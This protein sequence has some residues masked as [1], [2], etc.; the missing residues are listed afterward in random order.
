MS[1]SLHDAEIIAYS[2]DLETKEIRL[3]VDYLER[4]KVGDEWRVKCEMQGEVIFSGV[5]AHELRD[6]FAQN[7]IFE[8]GN[9]SWDEAIVQYKDE[10]LE[11]LEIFFY[12]AEKNFEKIDEMARKNNISGFH[13]DSSVGLRG[14]IFAEKMEKKVL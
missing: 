14:I 9:Y 8:I 12:N 13:L 1:F 7:V 11:I 5:I 3:K 4:E 2:V 10:T 6:C